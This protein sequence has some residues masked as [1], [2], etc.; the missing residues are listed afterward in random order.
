MVV[1]LN[2]LE[3]VGA[4]H[5]PATAVVLCAPRCADFSMVNGWV[6]QQDDVEL[7]DHH[8]GCHR[9]AYSTGVPVRSSP[10]GRTTQNRYKPS[11]WVG[12]FCI[13]W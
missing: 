4:I 7:I 5:D 12:Y 2:R 13:A 6:V 10:N 3:Y 11:A 9:P 1:Q 8:L